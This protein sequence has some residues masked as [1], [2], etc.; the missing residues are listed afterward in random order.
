MTNNLQELFIKA[1]TRQVTE[2]LISSDDLKKHD[3]EIEVV[4]EPTC[5]SEE[6]P[7]EP[8]DSIE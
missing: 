5:P 7:L 6:I 2:G 4:K 1:L 8:I 3:I